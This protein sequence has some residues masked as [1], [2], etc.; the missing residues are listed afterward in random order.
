[1]GIGNIGWAEFILILAFALIFFGPR[2]LPGIAQAI[3]K[4]L[5]EFQKA[6]NEVKSEIAQASK[7]AD[8]GPEL[9]RIAPH[10]TEFFAPDPESAESAPASDEPETPEG[11]DASASQDTSSEEKT[12]PYGDS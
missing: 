10:P 1:M 6:L 8:T 2:R 3:G 5:R 7:E 12:A 4:S 11:A 9:K